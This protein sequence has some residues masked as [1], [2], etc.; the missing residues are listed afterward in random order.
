M[1]EDPLTGGVPRHRLALTEREELIARMAARLSR[2]DDITF[3]YAFGS[4]IDHDVFGDVDVAVFVDET[5]RSPAGHLDA[6]MKL[7]SCL[8]REHRLPMDVVILND[9]PL[10]LRMAALRGR[11]IFSRD[12]ARRLSFAERTAMQAMDT[13]YLRTQSLQDL[14]QRHP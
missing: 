3:A 9:A 5:R 1:R 8:E 11:L 10:G 7:A 12:E 4:F 13:A 2:E 6:Q 14:L